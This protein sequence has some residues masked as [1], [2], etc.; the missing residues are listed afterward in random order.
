L[1][2][3]NFFITFFISEFA[4]MDQ[5]LLVKALK[6]LEATNKAEIIMFGGNEGVKFF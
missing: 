6:T 2:N 5:S 1:S 3:I 4:G